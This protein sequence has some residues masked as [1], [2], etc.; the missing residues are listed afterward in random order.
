MNGWRV[1]SNQYAEQRLKRIETEGE[2]LLEDIRR[3]SEGAAAD[4]V[5]LVDDL[6]WIRDL[7]WKLPIETLEVAIK[8]RAE[9]ALS[10]LG[11]EE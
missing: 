11:V 2:L 4:L 1:K 8:R 3:M 9:M 10:R 6:K 5:D 7:D